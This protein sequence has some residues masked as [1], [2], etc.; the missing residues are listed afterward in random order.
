MPASEQDRLFF[1]PFA[2]ARSG[3]EDQLVT[4]PPVKVAKDFVV[5]MEQN[6]AERQMEMAS[7]ASTLPLLSYA[8]SEPATFVESLWLAQELP[9]DLR[10][11]VL[12][13]TGFTSLPT[14]QSDRPSHSRQLVFDSGATIPRTL[15]STPGADFRSPVKLTPTKVSGFSYIKP[16][17]TSSQTGSEGIHAAHMNY[18]KHIMQE[19]WQTI[20]SCTHVANQHHTYI[21]AHCKDRVM[22]SAASAIPLHVVS[23]INRCQQHARMPG[24]HWT[25]RWK[26]HNTQ[27]K[28]LI[29]GKQG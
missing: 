9:A 22:H 20:H 17:D 4:N 11:F 24:E 18:Q 3:T 15:G 2:R 5:T 19:H 27:S 16:R 1:E 14:P 6:T 13:S 28:H 21:M 7:K 23:Y 29:A 10:A 26:H 12:G 25:R 8:D